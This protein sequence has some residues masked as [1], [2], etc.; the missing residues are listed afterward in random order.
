MRDSTLLP[1]LVWLA[2]E[3]HASAPALTYGKATLDF[4]ELADSIRSFASGVRG[5]GLARGERVAIYLEKRFETVIA[6]F[7]APAA[8]GVFVPTQPA[9]ESRAGGLH[10][11]RLQCARAGRPPRSASS[12]LPRH[13][14]RL[15]RPAAC[16]CAR[17]QANPCR[18][19]DRARMFAAGANCLRMPPQAR[20]PRHRHGRCGNP[21]H[22][23]QHRQA[24]GRRAFAPQHGCRRQERGQLS[25]KPP[26]RHAARR[27]APVFRRRLQPAHHRFPCRRPRRAAQLPAA[28]RRAQG[29]R[30]RKSHRPDRSAAAL[31]PAHTA[32]LAGDRSPNTCATSPTPAAACR[33]RRWTPCAGICRR[34]SP[35]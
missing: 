8:G 11:A 32:G 27:P 31:Y 30:T 9:V 17:L 24:E 6:S 5:L 26:G 7:G 19:I 15:P 28:A 14:S 16:G 18:S 12:C 33:A 2:A 25:G 1:E 20:A 23:G 35:I 29:H 34:R 10:P 3:R 22:L 21:L 4:A 13:P